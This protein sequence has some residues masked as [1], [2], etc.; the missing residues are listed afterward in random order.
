MVKSTGL[1]HA[2]RHPLVLISIL[3]LLLN[4]HLFKA[5]MASQFTG[6][7]SDLTGLFF[8][9]FLLGTVL[10]SLA[11]IIWPMR[12][13]HSR[14]ALVVSFVLS[15]AV[16]TGIKIFPAANNFMEGLLSNLFQIP[17]YIAL[18]PTDLAAFVVFIPA[19]MLWLR[20]EQ[21]PQPAAPGKLAYAMLGLSALACVATSP[22]MPIHSIQRLVTINDT[23]YARM[24]P[25]NPNGF[26]SRDLGSTW[27]MVQPVPAEI[28]SDMEGPAA[29]PLTLCQPEDKQN[30]Y[31]ISGQPWVEGS[32][33]GGVSWHIAWQIPPERE[34]YIN[35][36]NSSIIGGCGKTPNLIPLDM[37]FVTR[38]GSST[39]VVAMGNEGVVVHPPSGGWQRTAVDFVH[40]PH[41]ASPPATWTRPSMISVWN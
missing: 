15:A 19:W 21:G 16:F 24:E 22:C 9:P 23:L 39:L 37:A 5:V 33:D 7:L 29:L 13:F 28:L 4:D 14:L 3:V 2:F 8:F 18:D 12:R 26:L 10:Q 32:Q 11:K 31:R 30:C 17:V 38:S 27:E 35:R 20:I 34:R 1:L 25:G 36:A 41:A 6:K 40:A